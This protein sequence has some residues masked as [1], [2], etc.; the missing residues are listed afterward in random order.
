MLCKN[1]FILGWNKT[2]LKQGK[3]ILKQQQLWPPQMFKPKVV[4]Y[5]HTTYC[6]GN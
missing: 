6:P 5:I 3:R 2:I 4:F 1:V